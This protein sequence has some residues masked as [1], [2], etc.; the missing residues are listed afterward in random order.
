[1]LNIA[2]VGEIDR[3]GFLKYLKLLARTKA[4]VD[5]E[6]ST[7]NGH[8]QIR[9]SLRKNLES[10]KP[11][12]VYFKWHTGEEPKGIV[13]ITS[14]QPYSFSGE[15]YLNISVPTIREDR[16]KAGKRKKK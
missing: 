9:E 7:L 12:P 15:T 10:K 3:E 2:P 13:H 4:D 14:G 11:M 16:P 5:E 6:P 1:M 8:D